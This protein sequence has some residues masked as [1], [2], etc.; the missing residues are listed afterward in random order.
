MPVIKFDSDWLKANN[1]VS[2][3]D[4]IRFLDPGEQDKDGNWIFMVG[5]IPKGGSTV[6][7]K[8]KFSLNKKNFTAIA[9]TYGPDSDA[10]VGKE[11]AVVVRQVENPQ[12]GRE[13]DAVRLRAPGAPSSAEDFGEQPS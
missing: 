8:K 1:N 13:V 9:D 11:M 5:V 7:A 2:E 10:W 3:G 4:S 12:T 6:V